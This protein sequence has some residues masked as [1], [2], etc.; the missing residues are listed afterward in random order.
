MEMMDGDD[1]RR[2][3]VVIEESILPKA[4][5]AKASG[6]DSEPQKTAPLQCRRAV[7]DAACRGG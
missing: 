6:S 1:Y 2:P 7:D 4:L 3:G 5:A